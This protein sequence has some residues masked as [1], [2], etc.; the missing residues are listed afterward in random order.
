ML[1][2][3]LATCPKMASFTSSTDALHHWAQACAR[4]D[5]VIANVSLLLTLLVLNWFD[6]A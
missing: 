3:I 1:G 6:A 4:S 2:D 5:L